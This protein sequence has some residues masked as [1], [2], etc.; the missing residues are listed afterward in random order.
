MK[1]P[2]KELSLE[3][4]LQREWLITNGLGG[5]SSS[6]IIGINT[7]KYHGLLIAPLVPPA[8]RQLVLSKVDESISIDDKD[9]PLY[10][11][12][13]KNYIS[14]GYKYQEAFEKEYIPIFT[15]K[16]QG[17]IIKKLICMEY[18]KNTV[19]VQ[20]RIQ[21]KGKEAKFTL[22]PIVNFRDF[23]N[24]STNHEFDVSQSVSGTCTT[25]ARK[26]KLIIDDNSATPVYMYV[27][28]GEYIYH[29]DDTF[30]NMYYIEEEKR[31]FFPEENHLVPGRY[32]IVI[33]KNSSKEITFIC[34]LEENIEEVEI[35]K[36]INNEITRLHDLVYDSKIPKTVFSKEEI[37]RDYVIATDN[38]V[39]YRPNFALH[40]IIAGYPWF[41]DWGRDTLISFEGLLLTTKRFEV[42]KEVLLTMVRDIKFGLVPNGYSGH[43]NRPLY[44]SADSSLLLFQAVQK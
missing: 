40:T 15:Y 24:M 20:Y 36:V 31:G 14:D 28:E 1:I 39:V 13:C 41:L 35:E 29:S 21:N 33:P 16:V 2:K 32:E 19:C 22:T 23:H 12:M 34:S 9:Y 38:F 25:G 4:G 7:R 30:R 42:A 17:V 26:V 11:N 44:N 27:T 10:S 37:L 5:Y 3:Q 18:G 6:T 8:R 43:D